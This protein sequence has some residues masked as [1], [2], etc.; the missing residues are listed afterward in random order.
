MVTPMPDSWDSIPD[1]T[2]WKG[3]LTTRDFTLIL[4]IYCDVHTKT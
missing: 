1:P 2:R 3:K 4:Y